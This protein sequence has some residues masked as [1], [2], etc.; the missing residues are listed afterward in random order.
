MNARAST[1]VPS[2]PRRSE[3]I[4]ILTYASGEADL[5][6]RVV[7]THGGKVSLIA[8]HARRSKRAFGGNLELFDRG[9]F[10]YRR[11]SPL[12]LGTLSGF[13][14]SKGYRRLREDIDKVVA[15]SAL[16]ECVDILVKDES[17]DGAELF[18]LVA[19]G[20]SAMDEATS[21]KELLKGLNLS[22]GHLLKMTGFH[23]SVETPGT[24]SL[25]RLLDYTE[26]YGNVRMRTRQPLLDLVQRLRTSERH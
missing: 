24:K 11:A 3:G 12:I 16:C 7:T 14:P 25:T 26:E 2:P 20:L 9:T 17:G 1:R 5:V 22:L 15:A 4:V 8:K 10:D 13:T 19:L 18:D 6:L 23:L 21:T